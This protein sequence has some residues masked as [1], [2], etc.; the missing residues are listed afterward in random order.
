MVS[1]LL[2]GHEGDTLVIHPFLGRSMLSTH[3]KRTAVIHVRCTA[4]EREAIIT[5]ATRA[6]KSVSDYVRG[7]A[8][9]YATAVN[10]PVVRTAMSTKFLSSSDGRGGA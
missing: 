8:M 2:T 4:V 5:R 9:H 1:A 7:A 6:G 3:P 10:A